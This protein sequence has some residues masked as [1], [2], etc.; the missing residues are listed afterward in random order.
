MP[1]ILTIYDDEDEGQGHPIVSFTLDEDLK[2]VTITECCDYYYE[3]KLDKN[4]LRS[5]INDLKAFYIMMD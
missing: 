5:I 3:A 1:Q 2:S 4:T